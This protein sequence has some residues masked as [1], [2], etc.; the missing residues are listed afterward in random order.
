MYLRFVKR[1]E[2]ARCPGEAQPTKGAHYAKSH[3][4]ASPPAT[5]G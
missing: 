3:I 5:L 4:N 2:M 1:N